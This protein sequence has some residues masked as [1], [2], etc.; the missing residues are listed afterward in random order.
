M[1]VPFSNEKCVRRHRGIL[2]LRVCFFLFRCWCRFNIWS[3]SCK[4][5]VLDFPQLS[6]VGIHRVAVTDYL[7]KR[8]VRHPRTLQKFLPLTHGRISDAEI[9]LL[10]VLMTKLANAVFNLKH[11]SPEVALTGANGEVL[12]AGVRAEARVPGLA[13]R[14][15]RGGRLLTAEAERV[16]LAVQGLQV[17]FGWGGAFCFLLLWTKSWG[18]FAVFW[19]QPVSREQSTADNKG[20]NQQRSSVGFCALYVSIRCL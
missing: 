8:K 10:G 20:D 3:S 6:A 12:L 15:A 19:K 14:L 5:N 1:P 13:A 4:N 9:K 11:F 18:A 7:S 16:S 2:Y 17:A